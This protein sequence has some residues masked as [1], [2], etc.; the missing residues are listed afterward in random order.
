MARGICRRR[1]A[2]VR[3]ANVLVADLSQARGTRARLESGAGLYS[4]RPAASGD[5]DQV[6]Q[7]VAPAADVGFC[8]WKVSDRPGVVVL[9]FLGTGLLAKPARLAVDGANA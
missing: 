4:Q 6:G 3:V 5:K 8:R 9:S 2:G 7:A 1:R